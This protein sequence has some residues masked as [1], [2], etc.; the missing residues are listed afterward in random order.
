MTWLL[1]PVLTDVVTSCL[2]CRHCSCFCCPSSVHK[3]HFH[4]PLILGVDLTAVCAWEQVL[5]LFIRGLRNVY[6]TYSTAALHPAGCVYSISPH[7]VS[8]FFHPVGI[9]PPSPR[10]TPPGVVLALLKT[11]SGVNPDPTQKSGKSVQSILS[12]IRTNRSVF[13]ILQ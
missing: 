1:Y 6:H 3:V 8:E 5:H 2:F 11:H 4:F 10:H 13:C 12:V 7:A 9:L